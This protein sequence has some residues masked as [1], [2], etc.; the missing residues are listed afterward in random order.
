MLEIVYLPQDGACGAGL[1]LQVGAKFGLAALVGVI[2]FCVDRG[3]RHV[4]STF[5]LKEQQQH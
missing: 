4:Q 2:R 5:V 1:W 3:G